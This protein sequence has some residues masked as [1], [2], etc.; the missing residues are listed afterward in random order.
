MKQEEVEVG[1]KIV[2]RGRDGQTTRGEI[3]KI[4]PARAK[5]RTLEAHLGR[6]AGTVWNVPYHLMEPAPGEEALENDGPNPS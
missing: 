6:E 5:V 2:F 3:I 1:M 4:H